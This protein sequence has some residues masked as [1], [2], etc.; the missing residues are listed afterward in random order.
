MGADHAPLRLIAVRQTLCLQTRRDPG[1]LDAAVPGEVG[2][3]R[4]RCAPAG[5]GVVREAPDDEVE[6]VVGEAAAD[7]IVRI[8]QAAVQPE[9]RR[10]ERTGCDDD[11]LRLLRGQR[12][13]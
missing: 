5:T 6:V 12:A 1:L 8:R 11:D 13:A 4:G 3:R 9:P 7:L 10:L 2:A